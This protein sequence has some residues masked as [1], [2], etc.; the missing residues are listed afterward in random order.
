MMKYLK[1]SDDAIKLDID[2]NSKRF[3]ELIQSGDIDDEL[4]K[5]FNYVKTN[6]SPSAAGSACP[7]RELADIVQ[8]C[9]EKPGGSCLCGGS[10]SQLQLE[11]TA[12][13]TLDAGK[14]TFFLAEYTTMTSLLKSVGTIIINSAVWDG[15]SFN[16][17][18][19]VT[20][21]AE[22]HLMCLI[23]YWAQDAM[24]NA[25]LADLTFDFQNV[26]LGTKQKTATLRQLDN[27][28]KLKTV[29]SISG[30]R[31]IVLYADLAD[32]MQQEGR[33]ASHGSEAARLLVMMKEDNL[34]VKHIQTDTMARYI[35][36]GRRCLAPS[37][38]QLLIQWESLCKRDCLIDNVTTLRGTFT[39][40]DNDDDMCYILQTLM[41]QQRSGLRR[42]LV[43]AEVA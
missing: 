15:E 19:R 33:C 30:W 39:A 7:V 35:A 2:S 11:S 29:A 8:V 3:A 9:S 22:V 43:D 26:G 24:I 1:S 38:K 20:K 31:R 36:L 37:V 6:I 13:P 28:E 41:L 21:D 18:I 34:D 25:A 4:S 42:Q 10:L 12:V 16:N 23:A 5:A 40:S 32:A 17:L 14:I 27:E